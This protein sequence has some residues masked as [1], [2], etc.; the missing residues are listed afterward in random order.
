M[1]RALWTSAAGMKTQQLNVD[2]IANNLANVN[3]VGFK[4]ER[5]EF[6]S[7]LYETIKHAGD[8]RAGGSPV[9]LQVGH[10]VKA[11]SSVKSFSQG[12]LEQTENPLDFAVEGRGFFVVRNTNG[13]EVYTKD[14]SFKIS[15]VDDEIMLVTN[16]GLPVMSTEDEPILFDQNIIMSNLSMASDGTFQYVEDGETIDLGIRFKVVQFKNEAGLHSLGDNF[17][18]E[19]IASGE[20]L[21]EHENEDLVRSNIVQGMLETSNVQVVEEMVRLI[22]AQRAYE[23]NSKSIQTADTMLGQA[24]DLKR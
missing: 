15:V 10:G 14:G 11:V 18:K 7:L 6:K 3:T 5:L 19:T 9:N 13:D 4:K 17:Y 12:S 1:M 21:A 23:I 20:P 24:N 8:V 22:V 2:T 16:E